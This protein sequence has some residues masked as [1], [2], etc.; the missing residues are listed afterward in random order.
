VNFRA[1]A[2][3][4]FAKIACPSIFRRRRKS[5][6]GGDR[7]RQKAHCLDAEQSSKNSQKAWKL[8]SANNL[9]AKAKSVVSPYFGA[10]QFAFAY[11]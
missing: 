7:S 1:K 10:N 11:A 6:L 9:V 2:H 3:F 8:L 5:A 4:C